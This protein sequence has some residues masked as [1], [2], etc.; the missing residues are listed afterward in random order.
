MALLFVCFVYSADEQRQ[1]KKKQMTG[2]EFISVCNIVLSVA[3][4]LH[5]CELLSSEISI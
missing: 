1:T 3:V 2:L 5:I 4:D